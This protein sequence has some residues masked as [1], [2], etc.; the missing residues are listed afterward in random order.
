MVQ[1]NYYRDSLTEIE[2]DIYDRILRCWYSHL[3][4]VV[5]PL[6][7]STKWNSAKI[8]KAAALDH[9]EVFWVDYYHYSEISNFLSTILAF[10]FFMSEHERIEAETKVNTWKKL[11]LQYI[12][13]S[14]KPEGK[15][16]MIY[17]YL[18][19]QV[20]YAERGGKIQPYDFGMHSIIRSCCC[21]RRDCKRI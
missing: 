16:W 9:P 1:S 15:L 21:L 3:S 20:S 8:I 4:V 12:T 14:T 6:M 10:S 11:I 2:K 17:D 13:P 18:S 5:L 7:Y 19:R